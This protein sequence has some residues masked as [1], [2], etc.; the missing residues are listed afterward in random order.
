[1]PVD[2]QG[3]RESISNLHGLCFQGGDTA[4]PVNYRPITVP[5]NILRLITV[6]MCRIMTNIIEENKLL[7]EEQFGFRRKRSTIDGA[8]VLTTLMQK[9]K[10]KR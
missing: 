9:A 5:S 8:F 1:M 6:R 3:K 2:L 4:S 7:G 10:R